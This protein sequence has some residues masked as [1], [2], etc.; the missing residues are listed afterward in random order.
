MNPMKTIWITIVIYGF[1]LGI[2]PAHAKIYKWVDENGKSHFTNDPS[3]VPQ[4]ENAKIKTFREISPVKKP[5]LENNHPTE[6]T[7]GE[8]THADIDPPQKPKTTTKK[9][10]TSESLAKEKESYR[11]LLKK[12]R[13]SRERQLQKIA[14][15][16]KMDRKPKTW[17]TKESLDEII[18]GL[19]TNVKRSEKEIRKYEREIKSFSLTD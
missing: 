10:I 3:L 7:P 2:L 6:P 8:E 12:S 16:Q 4:N 13:E 5:V 9:E 14:E 1:I 17:S 11:E 18:E 19:Q 15:L